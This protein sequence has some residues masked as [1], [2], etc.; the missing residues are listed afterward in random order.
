MSTL[1]SSHQSERRKDGERKIRGNY[2]NDK[3]SEGGK[4]RIRKDKIKKKT[5]VVWGGQ[6]Q[7]VVACPRQGASHPEAR[8]RSDSAASQ[9]PDG[10][11][12]LG[13]LL[14]L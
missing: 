3:K 5:E 4:E 6:G 12:P 10:P 8:A 9:P 1:P 14:L 7:L 2:N 13:P 11:M